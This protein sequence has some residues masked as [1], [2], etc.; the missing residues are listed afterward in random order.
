MTSP[1]SEPVENEATTVSAGHGVSGEL[2]SP[3]WSVY[4]AVPEDWS[5]FAAS[6]DSWKQSDL[7]TDIPITWLTV[8]GLDPI[9]DV[10][11]RHQ[12]IRPLFDPNRSVTAIVCSQTCDLGGTPPGNAHPF[13]LLAPLVHISSIPKPADRKLAVEGRL[14]YLVKTLAAPVTHPLSAGDATGNGQLAPDGKPAKNIWFADL[15]LIFPASK[16]LLLQ[17]TP[18]EGFASED[19]RL[20]FA[21]TLAVKFR[22]AALHPALSEDLPRALDKFVRDTGHRNQAFAKVDEVRLVVLAGDRLRPAR[23]QLLVLSNGVTLSDAEQEVWARFQAMASKLFD[24]A[25][26][27]LG[28]MVHSNVHKLSA[29][30]YRESVPIRCPILN[31]ITYF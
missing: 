8:A 2:T 13:V 30:H 25:G 12:D 26:I 20:A 18:V 9:T 28:A 27:V 1:Q 15:R 23:A 10:T 11:N 3:Q 6:L 29:G 14:G 21:E 24:A 7:V 31:P 22:R 19:E 4:D 16:S 17:R 5:S